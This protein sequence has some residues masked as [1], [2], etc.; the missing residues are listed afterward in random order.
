MENKD[1]K[2]IMMQ[3]MECHLKSGTIIEYYQNDANEYIDATT[4]YEENQEQYITLHYV[5]NPND[6]YSIVELPKGNIDFFLGTNIIVIQPPQDWTGRDGYLNDWYYR[7][8]EKKHG[9]QG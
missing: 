8:E 9:N 1:M 4:Q 3:K 2:L 7:K 6:Y 5:N